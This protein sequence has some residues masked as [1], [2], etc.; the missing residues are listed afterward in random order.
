MDVRQII[1]RPVVSEKSYSRTDQGV[2]TFIVHPEA[3]KIQIRQAIEEIFHVKVAKVNTLNR[4][5][6]KRNNR[7]NNTV[8]SKPDTKQAMV[9]LVGDD[10]IELFQG[11]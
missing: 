6:K 3:S 7:R 1:Y 4:I 5:G 8:G 10:R 11:S 9:T 2:Y